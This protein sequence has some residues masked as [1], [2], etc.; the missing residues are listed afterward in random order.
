MLEKDAALRTHGA[1]V[2]N[3]SGSKIG[4]VKDIYLDQQTDQPEWA[5]VSTP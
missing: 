4:T 2:I 3:A 1:N 5:L